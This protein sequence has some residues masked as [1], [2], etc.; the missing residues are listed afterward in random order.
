MSARLR[1][2]VLLAALPL[3]AVTAT[4]AGDPPMG[5]VGEPDNTPSG[6]AMAADLILLRPLSLLGTV[7][8]TA[9]FVVGLPFEAASGNIGAG[10]RRLVKEPAQYTFTRPLGDIH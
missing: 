10:A 2:L 9:V 6:M 1:K 3:V 7:L 8:G 5:S 4:A